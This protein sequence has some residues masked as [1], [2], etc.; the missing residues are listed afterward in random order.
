MYANS[1][2]ALGIK[3]QRDRTSPAATFAA[4]FLNDNRLLEQLSRYTSYSGLTEARSSGYIYSGNR[5]DISDHV[6]NGQTVNG[7]HKIFIDDNHNRHRFI[8]FI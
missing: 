7:A 4:R 5:T 8:I 3:G 2:N 6:Q 1:K